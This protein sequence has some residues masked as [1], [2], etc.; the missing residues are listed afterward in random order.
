MQKIMRS[1]LISLVTSRLAVNP[2]VAL[3]GA[4]QVGKSTLA[5]EIIAQHKGAIYLDLELDSDRV[6]VERDP[7]FFFRINSGKLICLDEIQHTPNLFKTLRGVIDK[8]GSNG[9]FLILGSASRDLIKQSGESLAGRISY[10]EIPPFSRSEILGVVS[11]YDYWVKG[12]Y[13]KATLQDEQISYDWREDYI[14]SFLERDLPTLGFR[15]PA[16]TLKKFWTMLA[17][18]QGQVVNFAKLGDSLG[19]SGHTIKHYLDILE[20]TFVIRVLKP[21]SSNGKKRLVKSPKVYIRDT[22]LLHTIL[23]IEN[24]NELLG[25]P[26]TGGSFESMV[27]DNV[28]M[29]YPRHEVYYYRDSSGNEIDLLLV[30][31]LEMIAIE[32]KSSTAP[33]LSAGFWNAV[34]YLNPSKKIV[35]SQVN[36]PYPDKD[37][38]LITNLDD[39]LS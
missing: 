33:T 16:T 39:F 15:V 7:E 34:K 32:V 28:V 37:K 2:A 17:H 14:Q 18:S 8:T 22:G 36:T 21:Y 20:Q 5:K 38:L 23:K 19:V 24:I 10:I 1:N 27:I 12:G 4:R 31:G 29:K 30:K 6:K 25:H 35:I 13:P 9:Q 26:V 3:L 11:I